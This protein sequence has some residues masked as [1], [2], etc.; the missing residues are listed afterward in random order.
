MNCA[1]VDTVYESSPP[2]LP[3]LFSFYRQS[4]EM[5]VFT[6][7]NLRKSNILVNGND[8]VGIVDWEIAGWFPSYREYTC[9]R[10]VAVNAF[11]ESDIDKFLEPKLHELRMEHSRRQS[12]DF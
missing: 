1:K 5:P 12:C 4:F 11:S 9:A 2:N 6:H 10:S 7:G 3:E 8:I